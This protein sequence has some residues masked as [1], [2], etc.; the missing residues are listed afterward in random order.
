MRRIMTSI[1]DQIVTTKRQVITA[2]KARVPEAEL[3]RQLSQGVP[4]PR[5]FRAALEATPF[6]RVIAEVKRK[7]PSA[8][9]ILTDADAV[10]VAKVY[11]AHG[12][13]CISVLTDGPYFG[14]SLDDLRAVRAA[15]EVPLLR[16]DFILDRYQIL[17]ARLAGADAVLLIAEILSDA[18]L[19]SLLREIEG[20]G[21]DALA[22][23]YDQANVRRLVDAGATLIGVNN[24]DLRTFEVRLEQT[25]KLAEQIPPDRTLVSES[26]IQSRADIERLATAGIKAVLVGE[27]LM[28]SSDV[29]GTLRE[30]GAVAA[31]PREK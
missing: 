21:M 15:V 6:V 3:N 16:K 17:E 2:A 19:A 31:S 1:L 12:A 8:G 14:G 26:G 27:A 28:R 13:A 30:L 18:T 23:C 9:A 25:L 10:E 20:L 5:G 11:A 22:E 24:R 7:S 4:P 29:T